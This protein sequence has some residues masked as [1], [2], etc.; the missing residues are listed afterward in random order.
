MQRFSCRLISRSDLTHDVSHY[1]FELDHGVLAYAPGQFVSFVLDDPQT[2]KKFT[3]SYSIAGTPEQ[4]RQSLVS[5]QVML[6]GPRFDLVIIHVDHGKAT[7]ILHDAQVGAEFS[8]VGPAGNLTL[9]VPQGGGVSLVFCANSTGI[10]PFMA[11]IQYLAS[12]EV[13]PTVHVL[14]GLKT[15]RDIYYAQEL[16]SYQTV[17]A[18]HASLLDVTIC[19]SREE[20]WSPEWKYPSITLARGRIQ[21]PLGALGGDVRQYYICGGKNFVADVKAAVSSQSPSSAVYIERFD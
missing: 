18:D 10:A 20:I 13:F 2:S 11:M 9:R 15:V 16:T 12:A 17:W 21:G 8:A 4:G 6:V 7:T 14:W 1:V 5:G 3:R 19:L